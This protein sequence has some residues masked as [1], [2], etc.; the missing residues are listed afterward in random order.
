MVVSALTFTT[1]DAFRA[2][3]L[4]GT[5]I[6]AMPEIQQVNWQSLVGLVSQLKRCDE[7]GIT[8]AA[9]AMAFICIDTLANLSR[10]A[11]KAKVTRSDFKKWVDTYLKGHEDQ[12][13]HYPERRY[14]FPCTYFTSMVKPVT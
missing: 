13:Y 6:S 14:D 10:P 3:A 4:C 8:T 12:P 1:A 7:C 5:M 2:A 9:V 11:D